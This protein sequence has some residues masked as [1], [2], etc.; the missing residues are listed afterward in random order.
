M[1]AKYFFRRGRFLRQ[2]E[3]ANISNM[4]LF[5]F[6][7]YIQ[8]KHFLDNPTHKEGFT[9]NPTVL[10]SLCSSSHPQRHVISALYASL[11]EKT[12]TSLRSEHAYWE[13]VLG[14]ELEEGDWDKVNVYLHKGSLNVSVQENGYKSK[15]QWYRTPDLIHKFSSTVPE[16]CW[17]CSRETGSF[18][19]IWWSCASLQPYWRKVHEVITKVS[20]LPLEYSPAQYLLHL[21]EIPKKWYYISVA[22]HMVNAARMCV[23]M[24]WRSASPPTMV[25]WV[26][27]INRIVEMEELIYTSLDKISTFT[28]TWEAWTSFRTSQSYQELI[29]T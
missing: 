27:R 3:L 2:T 18:S 14:R 19:H 1:L 25:E 5:L 17:W 9:K 29:K 28:A 20:S 26:H 23:P 15:T 11:F 8:L 7:P 6:W 24:H 13:L 21:S 4:S 10:E 22:I 16:Q 12:P